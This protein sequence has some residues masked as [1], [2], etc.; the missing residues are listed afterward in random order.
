MKQPQIQ[1][2]GLGLQIE[3][4]ELDALQILNI[5]S[6]SQN[7]TKF[8]LTPDQALKVLQKIKTA[9]ALLMGIPKPANLI[10]SRLAVGPPAMR[11]SVQMPGM[12][13]CEDDL[14]YCYNQI[15]RVNNFLKYQMD[16]GANQTTLNELRDML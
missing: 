11:P 15:L 13:R 16:R 7:E 6:K 4:F 9:D 3:I 5:S 8:K 1:K 10:I 2:K 14:T 12:F